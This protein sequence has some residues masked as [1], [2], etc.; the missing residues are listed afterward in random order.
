MSITTSYPYSTG[1]KSGDFHHAV[2]SISG[3]I[4]TLYLDGSAVQ[5]NNSASD[6]FASLTTVNRIVIGASSIFNQAFNGFIGD[7]RVYNKAITATQ[8]SN[9]YMNRNLIAYYPFDASV[10]SLTPNYATLQYDATLVGSPTLTT[11]YIGTSALSLTNNKGGNA[12]Q[13]IVTTPG[14]FYLNSTTGLTISC[15]V[16]FDS[17]ANT[18]NIMRIFDIPFSSGTKGLGVDISGT[19]V[20]YSNYTPPYNLVLWLDAADASTWTGTTTKT[21]K[22]KSGWKNTTG[23]THDAVSINSSTTVSR[24]ISGGYYYMYFTDTGANNFSALTISNFAW[25]TYPVTYFCVIRFAS[26]T[27]VNDSFMLWDA[28]FQYGENVRNN[29]YTFQLICYKI[30]DSTFRITTGN[31]GG[32]NHYGLSYSPIT[33]NTFHI[34]SIQMSYRYKNTDFIRIDSN[35][36]NF[37]NIFTAY[38]APSTTGDYKGG[39]NSQN[40]TAFV[41]E[42]LLYHSEL[43]QYQYESVEGYLAWK[44]GLQNNLPPAHA[45]KSKAP[46]NMNP[47]P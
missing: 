14:N 6:I 17:A 10:N 30:D 21:W 24:N 25:I 2:L 5:I 46:V 45:Y 35:N 28:Y 31:A 34:V 8:V 47:Y 11:G 37:G 41:S 40:A 12:S 29:M 7:V 38:N 36:T 9:L 18:N 22:D 4:H 20:I 33:T 16:S 32:N 27:N 44:W 1:F 26:A 42:V 23:G 15:W 19:N 13:Y 43:S 3:T 39:M